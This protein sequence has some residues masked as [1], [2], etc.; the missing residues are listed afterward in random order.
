MRLLM[1]ENIAPQFHSIK[2][3][4]MFTSWENTDGIIERHGFD[5]ERS[6]DGLFIGQSRIVVAGHFSWQYHAHVA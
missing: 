6:Q 5:I 2:R 3:I 4:S 1:S